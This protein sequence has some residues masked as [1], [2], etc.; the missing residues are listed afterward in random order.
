MSWVFI[1]CDG[2]LWGLRFAMGMG[3]VSRSL[4]STH[5]SRG[6]AEMSRRKILS[7]QGH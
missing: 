3:V 4:R 6:S 7:V 5:Q 1:V 2:S